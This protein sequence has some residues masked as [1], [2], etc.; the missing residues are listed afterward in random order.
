MQ[1]QPAFAAYPG[2]DLVAAGLDDLANGIETL[3]SLLVSVGA[4]RLRAAGLDVPTEFS[5]PER[6]LYDALA[7]EN[8]DAAHGRYNALIRRLV[9]FEH[10]I[11]CA[12]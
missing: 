11:E 12:R 6:R 10:A 7:R 5:D 8:T 1:A 3:H 4:V 2:G 9:S